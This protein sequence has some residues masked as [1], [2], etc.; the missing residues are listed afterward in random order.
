M[1]ASGQKEKKN[2]VI[3]PYH[4]RILMLRFLGLLQLVESRFS[5]INPHFT[6]H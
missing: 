2:E 1:E 3:P 5:N 4:V 6:P